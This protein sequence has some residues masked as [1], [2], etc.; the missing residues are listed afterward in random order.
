[1]PPHDRP[2]QDR[3]PLYVGEAHN[4]AVFDHRVPLDQA[5]VAYVGVLDD[6]PF[7]YVAVSAYEDLPPKLDISRVK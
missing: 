7:L 2:V 6:H 4:H 5:R 3:S 1:M